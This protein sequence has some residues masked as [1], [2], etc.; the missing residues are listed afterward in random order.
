MTVFF[1][2]PVMVEE[3]CYFLLRG[4][5]VYVDA[6]VG[7][8]GHARA[9]L[10]RLGPSSMLVGIDRDE[11]ALDVARKTLA[12]FASRVRLVHERFSRLR[13]VLALFGLRRVR[14]IL[15]DLGVSSWQ[16][17]RGERGFSFR[18]EGPLDMRMDTSW[19]KTAFDLLHTLS[20]DE[21]A[22]LFFRFGEEQ[23]ARRIARAIVRYRKKKPI[24]TTTELSELVARVAPRRRIHPATRVFLALRIVVNDELG[25]L[26]R[27]LVQLPELLEEGGRVVVLSYHSLEDRLV[28]RHFRQSSSLQEVTKKPVFPSPE[29]V[30]RNP[31]ARS[32]R[33]RAAEKVS[34]LEGRA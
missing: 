5:G 30:R 33:L 34:F 25:E 6:T 2:E 15:F 8:G 28:K 19:G 7:G 29:E 24:T 11:E 10:E 1:H 31:R 26:E 32:A 16:L 27:A 14:G 21:L 9:I 12:P 18:R 17:E 23:Y 4:E 13:D 3:V 20:E 22:E